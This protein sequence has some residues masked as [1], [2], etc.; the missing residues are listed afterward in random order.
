[1]SAVILAVFVHAEIPLVSAEMILVPAGM[2]R[3]VSCTHSYMAYLFILS[4]IAL[5]TRKFP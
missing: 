4:R 5:L 1:M 3:V 2:T